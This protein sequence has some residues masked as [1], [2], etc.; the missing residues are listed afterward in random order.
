M[1]AICLTIWG[2]TFAGA[3]QIF[4]LVNTYCCQLDA[5][6]AIASKHVLI[7]FVSS[8][9]ITCIN[10]VVCMGRSRHILRCLSL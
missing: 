8:C 4:Y 2:K 9:C 7:C 10:D 5:Q 1:S 6:S 3:I